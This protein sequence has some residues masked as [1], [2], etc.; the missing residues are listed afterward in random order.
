MKNVIN[1]E[2]T[3]LRADCYK[4]LA[5]CLYPPLHHLFLE[6]DLCGK[7]ISIFRQICP[8]NVP[9]V[10]MMRKALHNFDENDLG[11]EYAALFVGPFTL[12][13]PPYGSVYLEEGRRVM[14]ETTMEVLEIYQ[15]AGLKVEA[16]EPPD[17]IVIELEF[18]YF[19]LCEEAR[20]RQNSEDNTS[21]VFRMQAQSFLDRHLGQWVGSFCEAI[22]SGTESDFYK[23]LSD[24]LITFIHHEKRVYAI[25]ESP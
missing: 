10:E 20:A 9:L 7:L 17:H 4:L 18:M 16:R 15:Q 19:L 2:D 14:G 22:T 13:A 23:A 12:Q 11:A 24:C 5:A 6:E 8:E 3:L 1:L 25:S 21:E